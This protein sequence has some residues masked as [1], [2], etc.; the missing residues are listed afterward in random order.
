MQNNYSNKEAEYAGFWVRFSAYMIDCVLVFF[1]LLIIRVIMLGVMSAVKGTV[2]GGNILFHYNLKDI[3]LYVLQVLYFILCTYYTG[4]TLGKKAMNLRVVCADREEE[5]TLLNVIYRET[6]G[7]FLSGAIVGAGYI[8]AGID[9]EKRGLHDIL[10]DT[11][12]IYA[13]KIKVIETGR[14][15]RKAYVEGGYAA[16]NPAEAAFSEMRYPKTEKLDAKSESAGETPAKYGYTQWKPQR[17]DEAGNSFEGE[18][19]EK[20][21]AAEKGFESETTE[22]PDAAEKGFESETTEKPNAAE[23]SIESEIIEKPDEAENISGNSIPEETGM[24]WDTPYR[25]E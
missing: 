17:P 7:R 5:L 11:R 8:M 13:K 3:V 9:G 12:V 15:M 1:A 24:P 25:K 4:T 6:I 10:C 14:T 21:D 2:L 19:T 23:K 22:K 16:V 18:T 20:P